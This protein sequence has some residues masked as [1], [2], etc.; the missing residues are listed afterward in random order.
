MH[1]ALSVELLILD[2]HDDVDLELTLQ[3]MDSAHASG[4]F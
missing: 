1:Q 4:A 2:S 3:F